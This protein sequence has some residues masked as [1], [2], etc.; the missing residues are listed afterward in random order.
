MT[1]Y[2]SLR[3]CPVFVTG[4]ATGIGAAIV[5]AFA[6]QHARVG[7]LDIDAAAAA[8]LIEGLVEDNLPPPWFREVDV[9]DV[10]ALSN[11]LE[12]FA[13]EV[14]ATTVLVNNVADDTR[15]K[16]QDVTP[17]FWRRCLAVNLDAAYF[18]SQAVFSAMAVA[19][20]GVILNLSSINALLGPVDM[21]G[22]VTAKAGLIG[23]TKALAREYGP[24]GVRVNGIL[25]GW[26]ATDRQLER[27]LTPEAEA[28]WMQH[29][30]LQTRIQAA[31][32]AN[33]A[34]FLAA[35]DSAMITGQNIAIDGGRT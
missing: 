27:W 6:R 2:P 4:G 32:V 7:F 5:A 29:V 24:S 22:Y 14:A 33:L 1:I 18:A 12:S 30:A 31:D 25:P 17:E 26:V 11:A 19:R 8:S 23:M 3:D 10:A 28:E 9:T 13:T 34:L 15:H 21:P 20:Q 16:P 35:D